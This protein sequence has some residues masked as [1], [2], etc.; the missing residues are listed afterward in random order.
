MAKAL[1]APDDLLDLTGLPDLEEDEDDLTWLESALEA[2]SESED[3]K[4]IFSEVATPAGPPSLPGLEMEDEDEELPDW[5]TAA[6]DEEALEPAPEPVVEAVGGDDDDLPDWLSSIEQEDEEEVDL[7]ALFGGEEAE[8]EP[9]EIELP[10]EEEEEEP[11]LEAL[12]QEEEPV[13]EIDTI[14]AETVEA[15]EEV[16][17]IEVVEAPP[18]EKEETP[19]PLA[20]VA[21]VAEMV[22]VEIP[23]DFQEQLRL[24]REKLSAKAYLEALPYYESMISG[25]QLLEQTVSDLR[26]ALKTETKPNP[27]IHRVLGDALNAQGKLQEALE[28]YRAALDNL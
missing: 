6:A 19:E 3:I 28:A 8:P 11:I 14:E 26:Y 21:P 13:T 25:G 2:E 17:P 16:E 15:A 23:A 18:W 20:E 24:A 12:A 5:L 22:P 10:E 1:D 27:R 9:A 7:A 4:E